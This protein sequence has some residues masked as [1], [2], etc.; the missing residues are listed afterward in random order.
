MIN[1]VPFNGAGYLDVGQ[2]MAHVLPYTWIWGG[3][4]TGKTYGFL[5]YVRYNH[6]MR[7]LI[8]RRTQKQIDLLR[9]PAFNPFKPVDQ[10][11]KG[12]TIC[13]KDGEM[14]VFYAG[15]EEDGK[16]LPEG[17][18][19]GYAVAL[20]T[21]HNVRGIDLSDVEIVIYDE[22]IPEPHERPIRDE[23]L[24]FLNAMETIGRNRE[25][26]G[27]PP[28]QFIGLSNSNA[29]GNPYF[30]GLQV[31]RTVD[32]MLQR[33]QE[34]WQDPGRGLMLVNI[35]R[36]PVSQAKADTSLYKLAGQGEF[37]DMSLGNEFAQDFCSRQGS[38]PL[39]ECRPLVSVGEITIYEH[40]VHKDLL[41]CCD[42]LSGT[43][44]RYQADE[45]SIKR[46]RRDYW[47]L[48]QDYMDQLFTFKDIM[49]EVLFKRY[50]G[51]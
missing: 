37:A 12:I 21:V 7:F 6:P 24:A 41:Y 10:D 43:P 3:R 17:L 30:L 26:Q 19:L 39:Q 25:L 44:D 47:Y 16:L 11:H 18:P 15:R 45:T 40:K 9:K 1:K 36:S 46:F 38:I 2:L 13:R 14:G 31:I 5:Q 4:G 29:L 20:S 8:L 49:C 23:Y 50:I 27:R 32:R 28:M 48:Q 33:Q 35:V 51:I 42:H 34:I 22:Y